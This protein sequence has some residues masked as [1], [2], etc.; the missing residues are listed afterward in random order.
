MKN[1]LLLYLALHLFIFTQA[2][3][4]TSEKGEI[5]FFSDAVIEDISAQNNMAGSLFSATSADV[6][7]LSIHGVT[8]DVDLPGTL[9]FAGGKTILKSKFM[10][11]LK[12]YDIKIPKLVWQNIAEEIE[13]KIEFIYKPL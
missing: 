5:S 12:D 11:M 7:K 1:V 10:V 6:N 3:K 8:R 13:V 4:F 2:Q 9:E